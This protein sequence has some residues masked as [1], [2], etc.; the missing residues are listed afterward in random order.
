MYADFSSLSP[1]WLWLVI[2]AYVVVILV[3][4]TA[5]SGRRPWRVRRVPAWASASPGVERG[6]GYTSFG[7]ANP[8]RKVLANLLL[9]H[10]QLEE[11]TDA[12]RAAAARLAG[13]ADVPG[14]PADG[15]RLTYQVDVVEIVGRYLYRPAYVVLQAA[16]RLATRLQSGRLDAYMG[17]MLI[18]LL[19]VV[20]L[21]AAT[22]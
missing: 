2:P 22:S 20:A 14:V 8:M 12:E 1:S 5:L 7:Y 13:Q 9:T 16:A 10:H 6:V 3:A 15:I 19:A 18:V 11:V 17:Y 21:V 4:V